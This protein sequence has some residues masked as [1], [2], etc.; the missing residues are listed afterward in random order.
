MAPTR[1]GRH[2]TLR[3]V[4]PDPENTSVTSVGDNGTDPGPAYAPRAGAHSPAEAGGDGRPAGVH[5]GAT[6]RPSPVPPPGSTGLV[7]RRRSSRR[8]W[9]GDSSGS[10]SAT[11][12]WATDPAACLA[13]GAGDPRLEVVVRD[14]GELS[15]RH[16]AV[17][18]QPRHP[19]S[20]GTR[21]RARAGAP[22]PRSP[23]EVPLIQACSS[24][25]QAVLHSRVCRRLTGTRRSP[26][27]SRSHHVPDPDSRSSVPAQR[28]Q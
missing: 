15:G 25:G 22:G 10:T 27:R 9:I 18:A 1:A 4:L 6:G 21:H 2:R 20:L 26:G 14:R 19:R 5:A 13:L 11:A 24:R 16:V 23:S 8:S 17:S 7:H 3:G 12:R 28:H